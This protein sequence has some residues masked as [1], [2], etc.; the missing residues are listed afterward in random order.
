LTKKGCA[1]IKALNFSKEFNYSG[2]IKDIIY[3]GKS[4]MGKNNI[5]KLGESKDHELII[6]CGS[7][8]KG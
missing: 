5:I 4:L 1:K 6:N 3:D 8:I 7:N 2:E